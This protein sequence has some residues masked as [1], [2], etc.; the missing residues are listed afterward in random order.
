MTRVIK[1]CGIWPYLAQ[2]A[3]ENDCVGQ[4]LPTWCADVDVMWKGAIHR[5]QLFLW[6]TVMD[7]A[8]SLLHTMFV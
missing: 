1:T 5:K 7:L 2:A 8:D 6:R 3:A 4:Q